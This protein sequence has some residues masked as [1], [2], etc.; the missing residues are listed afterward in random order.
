MTITN[1]F[2]GEDYKIDLARRNGGL[3]TCEHLIKARKSERFRIA[4]RSPA[5]RLRDRRQRGRKKETLVLGCCAGSFWCCWA[6]G[7]PGVGLAMANV[8]YGHGEGGEAE[9]GRFSAREDAVLGRS[10]IPST[11]ESNR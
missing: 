8:L 9:Q 5:R 1:L 11:G 7:E 2:W 4:R 3:T 10:C 6:G